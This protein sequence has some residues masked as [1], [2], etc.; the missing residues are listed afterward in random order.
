M[1]LLAKL[2]GVLAGTYLLVILC[3]YLFQDRLLFFPRPLSPSSRRALAEHAI[4]FSH[5]GVELR[6]WIYRGEDPGNLPFVI[7]YGGNA[8]ELSWFFR[9][10]TRLPLSGFLLLNYRGY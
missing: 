4:S 3:A 10:F 8:A 2:T 5:D 1:K 9:H 6:G 7:Y